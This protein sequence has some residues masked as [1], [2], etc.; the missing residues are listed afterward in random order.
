[1]N[2]AHLNSLVAAQQHCLGV[3]CLIQKKINNVTISYKY[4]IND[5]FRLSF[6]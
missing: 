2:A 6:N 4:F 1:M 3:L 5:F